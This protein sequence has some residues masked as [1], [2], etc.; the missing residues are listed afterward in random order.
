MHFVVGAP[1][2]A[3]R[4]RAWYEGEAREPASP[5]C[6]RNEAAVVCVVAASLVG[7]GGSSAGTTTK[8]T[9]VTD[10]KPTGDKK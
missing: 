2:Q 10:T 6:T 5:L 9:V 3:S 7:C 1:P 8:S 4:V